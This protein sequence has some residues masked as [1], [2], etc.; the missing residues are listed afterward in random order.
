[1]RH[2][3]FLSLVLLANGLLGKQSELDRLI[4]GNKRYMKGDLK[5]PNRTL[6]RRRAT[7]SSQ[8]PFAVVISCSDSRVS[9]EIIFDEGIG[10]IFII[11]LAG[12]V[13][14]PIARES[15]EYAILNLHSSIVLVLGHENC[16]A[17]NAVLQGQDKD[18]PEIATLISPS[19]RAMGSK[20]PKLEAA[21][22]ANAM[23]MRN[24][25]AQHPDFRSLVAK[26]KLKIYAGYYHLESGKVEI[27]SR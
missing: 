19:I 24:E 4:A 18:I 10:D 25:L 20:D 22:K 3:F 9:P 27:L 11:R 5:H 6:E 2:I 16:G 26:K 8:E 7:V 1:M 14:G 12:N 17:V 15:I 21:V 13:I 23:R